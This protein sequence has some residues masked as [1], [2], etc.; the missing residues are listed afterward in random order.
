MPIVLGYRAKAGAVGGRLLVAECFVDLVLIRPL[1][2]V[3]TSVW[4]R[5]PLRR[6]GGNGAPAGWV[7]G[8]GAGASRATQEPAA[9]GRGG[10]WKMRLGIDRFEGSARVP[11]PLCLDAR[12]R[13]HAASR[14]GER[15]KDV[16]R[17]ADERGHVCVAASGRESCPRRLRSMLCP[18]MGE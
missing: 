11:Q 18:E 4:R 17:S 9:G 16:W 7:V 12:R 10:A 2:P 1:G 6:T 14:A 3:P 5:L 8:M 15:R 13:R